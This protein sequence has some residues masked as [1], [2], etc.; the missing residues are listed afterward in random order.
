MPQ[1]LT[2]FC[3][4]R[5]MLLALLGGCSMLGPDFESPEAD[6]APHW[7]EQV[8]ITASNN[9]DALAKWWEVLEDEALTA[10]IDTA[11]KQ[12]LSLQVSALRIFEA[13][14]A[15]GIAGGQFYPQ[16]QRASGNLS[17]LELSDDQ[18]GASPFAET[19]FR[20]VEVGFDAAWELD[21]WGRFRRTIEAADANLAAEIASYDD[22]L[23]SLTAEVASTY[24]A[25]R[26][27]QARL[28]IARENVRNQ[29]DS[30]R[31]ATKRFE[32]GATSALDVAQS[33][34]LLGN[35]LASIPDLET[36]LRQSENA[37]RVLL[38]L[39]PGEI[40]ELH[41]ST[42]EIPNPP[43]AVALGVPADL[44]R[45]R[46]DIRQAERQAAAQ[47]ARIGIARADLYPQFSLVGNVG[48]RASDTGVSEL[49]DLFN[50]GSLQAG[51][52]PSFSWNILNYGRLKNA[53]RVEDAR[54]EQA[55]TT[56]KNTVLGAAREVEDALVAFARGKQR[57]AILEN[58]VISARRAVKLALLQYREGKVAYTRVLDTQ[59][60][61]INQQD[62][63]VAARGQLIRDLIAMFKALGGGWQH[64]SN[65]NLL[66]DGMR[67]RMDTRTDWGKLLEGESRDVISPA[68]RMPD[69]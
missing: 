8:S 39:H 16:R 19:S 14:A 9:N 67:Q 7:R 62:V 23:V 64:A 51:F 46:P 17:H 58:T 18:P 42:G 65:V 2:Q 60:A 15:L 54:L 20:D 13:R 48:L 45:R 29:K 30:L 6:V 33:K 69:W 50:A 34:T 40:S 27:F 41:T 1:G 47:S 49:G 59:S 56:Y 11:A 35:T 38:G 3:R 32:A 10:L 26:T 57:V 21:L 63:H 66:N 53:V 12:N 52:G 37:L 4:C 43:L 61:L 22:A 44:L 55:V 28:D 25:A 24:I 5:V 68:I 36:G 31:I